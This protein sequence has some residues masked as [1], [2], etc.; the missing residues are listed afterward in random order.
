MSAARAPLRGLAL[1]AILTALGI[2]ILLGLGFWQLERLAWKQ[3]LIARVE[4]RTKAPV[5]PLPPESEW[6]DVNAERDEYR[7]VSASGTLRHDKEVHVYTVVSEQRGRYAGPGYWVLTPLQLPSGG[8]VI[9]NRGFVPVDRKDPATRRLGQVE[10]RVTVTGLQRMPEQTNF[11]TPENDPA[12]N[13]WY[14]RDPGEI[15]RALKLDRAAPFTIDADATPNPGGLPQG[16]DTR[17]NFPNN[18]LQYAITW[19]GLVLALAGV[20][21]VFV[22]QRLRHGG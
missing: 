14:R 17:V 6:Q 21:A 7:R 22:W 19:F 10:G 12:R 13:A 16:G 2:A 15:A 1:L 8:V 18:H 9:V 20:F 4:A 3:N 5:T 11:F